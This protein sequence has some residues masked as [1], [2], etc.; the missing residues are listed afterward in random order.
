MCFELI[1]DVEVDTEVDGVAIEGL[2]A[3]YEREIGLASQLSPVQSALMEVD[4][5]VCVGRVV[6]HA[7]ASGQ[8]LY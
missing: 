5:I 8:A 2:P 6:N 3:G 4:E 1:L 7:I